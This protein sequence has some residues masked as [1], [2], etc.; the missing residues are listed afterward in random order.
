MNVE[1][2]MDKRA[3]AVKKKKVKWRQ[4]LEMRISELGTNKK[5]QA[6]DREVSRKMLQLLTFVPG[7]VIMF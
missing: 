5:R 7:S 4:M 2:G 6:G 1:E 3:L